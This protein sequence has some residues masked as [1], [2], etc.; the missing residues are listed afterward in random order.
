MEFLS[1]A[2]V[3]L[4]E[5]AI[6]EKGA[7]AARV[8]FFL[9]KGTWQQFLSELRSKAKYESVIKDFIEMHVSKGGNDLPRGSGG[10]LEINLMEYCDAQI[11]KTKIKKGKTV[12][13]FASTTLRGHNSVYVKYWLHTERGELALICPVLESRLNSMDKKHVLTQ[14]AT[15][16]EEEYGKVCNF[17]FVFH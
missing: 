1:D 3:Q 14:A 16:T 12:K 5:S 4:L 9:N 17:I 13:N 2:A 10:D 6:E 11:A 7:M 15:L 8:A